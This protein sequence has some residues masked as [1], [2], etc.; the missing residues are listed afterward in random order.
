MGAQLR[1]ETLLVDNAAHYA[2]HQRPDVVVPAV[3]RFAETLREGSEWR[4]A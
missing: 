1:A 2:Q 3:L 4:R